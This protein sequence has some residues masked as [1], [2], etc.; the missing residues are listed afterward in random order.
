MFGFSGKPCCCLGEVY[1]LSLLGAGLEVPKRGGKLPKAG[2]AVPKSGVEL[3]KTGVAFPKAGVEV[4]K[5]GTIRARYIFQAQA[6]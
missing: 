6:V 5:T 2:V 4:P 3:L 1:P